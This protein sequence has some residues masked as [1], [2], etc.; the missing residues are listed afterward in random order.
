LDLSS[1]AGI[2]AGSRREDAESKGTDILGGGN[3]ESSLLYEFISTIKADI[4]GHAELNPDLV[5]FVGT[6]LPASEPAATVV[7]T[8]IP[9]NTPT[10]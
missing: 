10:P 3:W 8:E 5:I 2:L 1:Y 9:T 4:P 6:P 7:P